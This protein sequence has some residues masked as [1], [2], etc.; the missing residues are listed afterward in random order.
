MDG[1]TFQTA[2]QMET[3]KTVCMDFNPT[4]MP[5]PMIQAMTGRYAVTL[6]GLVWSMAWFGE[7]HQGHFQTK[8]LNASCCA[9]PLTLAFACEDVFQ[10]TQKLLLLL[11]LLLLTTTSTTT[12]DYYYY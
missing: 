8:Y 3:L 10:G 9:F 5:L 1:H 7:M 2:G 11:L 6:K 4:R 12:T